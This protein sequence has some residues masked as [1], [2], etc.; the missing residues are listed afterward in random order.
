MAK[1]VISQDF[2]DTDSI[3][4]TEIS[5]ITVNSSSLEK[6]IGVSD[7]RIRQL[8][9]ENIIIRA[10]KGRYK[11][12]ESIANYILT[13]KVSMEANSKDSPDGEID[14]EEEKAIHERVKRH[15]SELKLQVM[16]GDLHKSE[17][18]ERVMADMLI[19]I[20]TKLLSMP[21]KLAPILAARSDIEFIKN[22]INR[23]VLEA[24]NELK[25]YNPKE[26]YSDDTVTTDGEDDCY[27]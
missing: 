11:L 13:L 8:A 20:K 3:K 25:E 4:V 16:K 10:S 14:L 7:R 18:V 23:E 5:A 15:I 17:D 12:M 2:D 26:F 9:E 24:L 6:I 21:T 22:T 27:A 19:S 1:R